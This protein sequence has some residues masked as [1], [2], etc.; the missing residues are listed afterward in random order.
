MFGRETAV[1]LRW[2][3]AG[4]FAASAFSASAQCVLPD[5]LDGGPCWG[6]TTAALPDFPALATTV[7]NLC[8]GDCAVTADQTFDLEIT[9]PRKARHR[10]RAPI[11]LCSYYV[12]RYTVK[13]GAGTVLWSGAM[14]LAY[15]RTWL[16]TAGATSYQVWRFLANGDLRPTADAGGTPCP[17]PACAA[18]FN[19]KVHFT[20][21][22]DYARHCGTGVFESAGA[23]GHEVDSVT[24]VAGFTRSGAFHPDRGYDFVWPAEGFTPNTNVFFA[25]EGFP[26]GRL[27][28]LDWSVLPASSEIEIYESPITSSGM[29]H[30]GENVCE[31][32]VFQSPSTYGIFLGA[33]SGAC[34]YQVA[35]A[36]GLRTL[37][38]RAIGAW[39]DP[40]RFPGTETLLLVHGY[41]SMVDPCRP[42][43][44]NEFFCGVMTRGGFAARDITQAGAA[45][46]ISNN[47]IDL[48]NTLGLPPAL[49]VSRNFKF[50][51]D[52]IVN[53]TFV[54]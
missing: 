44:R 17:V 4:L 9:S 38:C 31:G 49:A 35:N 18:A 13:D 20:G 24:H 37:Y 48:G 53:V 12:A 3:A 30:F 54:F 36:G 45:G 47:F 11:P 28:P 6:A 41:M 33:T 5:D 26:S 46:A 16:E 21:Y 40:G 43:S 34:G 51:T 52:F 15:S 19:N 8:W 27:R 10:T 23:L 25:R 32:D 1:V 22:V 14:R 29:L 50:I 42:R 39:S 7:R 2:I